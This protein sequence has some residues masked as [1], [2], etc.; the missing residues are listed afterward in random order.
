MFSVDG[1]AD[2]AVD[3]I[4]Y[5]SWYHCLPITACHGLY[6]STSCCI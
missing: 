6:C 1:D 5:G 3:G 4:N 2:A